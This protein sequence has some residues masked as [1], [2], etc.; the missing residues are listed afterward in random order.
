MAATTIGPAGDARNV[1]TIAEG[2]LPDPATVRGLA[3]HPSTCDDPD[4]FLSPRYGLVKV[5][6]DWGFRYHDD[7]GKASLPELQEGPHWESKYKDPE[8]WEFMDHGDDG[9]AVS[10]EVQEDP[11][12]ESWDDGEGSDYADGL[13]APIAA[14]EAAEANVRAAER[15]RDSGQSRRYGKTEE[16]CRRQFKEACVKAL[17]FAPEHGALAENIADAATLWADERDEAFIGRTPPP[18]LGTKALLAVR[19]R[20]RHKLT[21]FD[22]SCTMMEGMPDEECLYRDCPDFGDEE[23]R[24]NDPERPTACRLSRSPLFQKHEDRVDRILAKYRDRSGAPASGD[25]G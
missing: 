10:T 18:D 6:G 13:Y 23:D 14:I 25:G 15:E 7:D 12:P 4:V 22:D 3:V 11:D 2:S 9:E 24:R 5:P 8:I 16:Q 20:I 21:G 1:E 17:G 19:T